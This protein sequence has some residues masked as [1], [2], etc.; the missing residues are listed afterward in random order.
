MIEVLID[1]I[2][3]LNSVGTKI[4][5]QIRTFNKVNYKYI[6]VYNINKMPLQLKIPYLL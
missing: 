3:L 4:P 2:V 1:K 6:F 5:F